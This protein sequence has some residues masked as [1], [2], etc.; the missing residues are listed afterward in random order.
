MSGRGSCRPGRGL[1]LAAAC[2]AACAGNL[3]D[4]GDDGVGPDANPGCST[5]ITFE[6]QSP[7]A[8]PSAEVRANAGVQNATGVF[9]YTWSV[10]FQGA[11]IAYERAQLD[12]SAIKFPATT[13]GVYTVHLGVGAPG[14][15]PTAQ[16]MLNVLAPGANQAQLRLRVTPPASA[17]APP[18][19]K[20]VGV[21]GGADF[22]VGAIGLDPGVAATAVVQSG[23]A[24][25]ASYLRLM[26]VAAR[27][28]AVELFTSAGGAFS[29]SVLGQPH[30]VLVIPAVPGYAPAL[31]ED[32]PPSSVVL[33]I[34]AG[35]TVTGVV[36]GPGGAPLAGAKVQLKIGQVP[37]TLATTTA[38][39]AF[40]LLVRP[41]PGA[42]VA[43]DVAPP[44]GSGLPRLRAQ[45]TTMF[46]LAQPFQ[47]DYAASLALRDLGGATIRRLGQPVAGAKVSIVGDLI[48]VGTVTAGTMPASASGTVQITATAGGGGQLPPTLAPAR[49][50]A[51]VIEAAPNDHAVTAI[52]LTSAAPTAIDAPPAAPIATQLQ[53]PDG[54][55]IAEAVLDA[56]PVGELAQAGVTSSIR[57]RS[58]AGGQLSASLAA[59]GRYD[60]RIHDPVLA[61]GA[62]RIAPGVTAQ[63]IAASYALGPALIA[64]GTLLLQGSPMG[65][66]AVQLLCSQ[67]IGVERSRPLAEGTSRPDGTFTLAVPD[68]GTN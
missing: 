4:G 64:T 43:V 11:P 36:R 37:S 21:R 30:D 7:V 31:V 50:L 68:P 20:L 59:G 63:T 34:G 55:P 8:S 39:G 67:C 61:R 17:S 6:P 5:F 35:T 57:A 47:I 45:S 1:P 14:G 19:E 18:F 9:E 16:A 2:L 15:C 28:A 53:R 56:V 10:S 46:D 22:F 38:S 66:A 26:P 12:G 60:L 40:S 13:P 42:I 44:A 24:G 23:G 58:G 52:D 51:A 48:G 29:A 65:G 33:D 54:T 27:E 49:Q 62:P 41:T 3:Q 32:W 25:V